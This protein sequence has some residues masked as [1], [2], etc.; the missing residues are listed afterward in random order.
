MARMRDDLPEPPAG[1]KEAKLFLFARKQGWNDTDLAK[2]SGIPKGII[3]GYRRGK[4]MTLMQAV[5]FS[6][7]TGVSLLD[8]VDPDITEV[9]SFEQRGIKLTV[10]EAYLL[11]TGRRLGI[12]EAIDRLIG[13]VEA[14]QGGRSPTVQRPAGQ[15]DRSANHPEGQNKPEPGR[16]R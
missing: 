5:R 14:P 11:E 4:E 16:S 2:A 9:P 15:A 1:T 3:S 13:A 6:K 7:A 8:L 12:K 10:D